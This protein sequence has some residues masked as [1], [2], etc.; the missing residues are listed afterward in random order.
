MRKVSD[1]QTI[2]LALRLGFLSLH[3]G[4]QLQLVLDTMIQLPFLL[5]GKHFFI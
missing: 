1:Q 4:L 5:F 3:I 2:A